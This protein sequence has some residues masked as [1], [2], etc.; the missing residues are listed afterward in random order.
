MNSNSETW[1]KTEGRTGPVGESPKRWIIECIAC[2]TLVE[3]WQT[4]GYQYGYCNSCFETLMDPD[5]ML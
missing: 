3:P 1:K 2:D 5:K 4:E